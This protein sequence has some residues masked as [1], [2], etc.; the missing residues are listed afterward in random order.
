MYRGAFRG[1]AERTSAIAPSIREANMRAL[2]RLSAIAAML[3]LGC[4]PA[5]AQ[6]DDI[7]RAG[8]RVNVVA[9]EHHD[10]WAAGAVVSV[11]GIIGHELSVAGAEVDVDVTTRGDTRLAGA[12]VSVKGRIE[13]DLYVAGARLNVDARV[14]GSLNA[15]GARLIVGSQSEIEGPMRIGGADVVF[16]GNSRGAAE[17]YGD[18]VQIDG[19]I[20]GNLLVRARS[21]TVGKTAVLEGD[22]VFE[23][24]DDPNIEEGATLR[25]RQTVTLPR[26][27]PR[28]P[29]SIAKALIAV[30][31]FGIG[32]GLVLGLIL[33]IAARPLVEQAISQFRDAPLRSLLIGLA[34]LVLVPL[35]A[36]LLMVTVIG[37]PV[38]LLALLAF[39]LL[40]LVAWVL[41]AFAVAD[42]LFNRGRAEHSFTGRLLLLLAGLGVVT[43]AGIVP[44]VGA[45]VWL[46]VMLL[47]L[48]ALWQALR[49]RSVQAPA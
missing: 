35:I 23:T 13:K 12:I 5:W 11:R 32:A 28:E 47:G 20:G 2:T 31:L 29:W 1:F 41:A 44:V 14:G 7:W 16:A 42:W 48:G 15:A 30:A 22:V 10:V 33:L 17:I 36:V 26:P 18:T 4:A 34:V 3:A 6:T 21:V 38:G 45:L 9:S 40:L 25:G 43:L 24:L 27:G 19:R 8:A 46:L 39:P 37:I 49:I